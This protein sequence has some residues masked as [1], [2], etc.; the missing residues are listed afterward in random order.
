MVHGALREE[1]GMCYIATPGKT[2]CLSTQFESKP[3]AA[4]KPAKKKADSGRRRETLRRL[5][6]TG[7]AQKSPIHVK[8]DLEGYEARV[9][10]SHH[11]KRPKW[12]RIPTYR[13]DIDGRNI[14]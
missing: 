6:R 10:R 3:A 8:E 11:T 2:G 7:P 1:V 9:Y 5:R 14:D 4:A 13:L 12:R